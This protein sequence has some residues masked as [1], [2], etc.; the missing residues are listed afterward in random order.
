MRAQRWWP[1]VGLLAVGTLQ[2]QREQL[3]LVM[4]ST[5]SLV[6]R[7]Y[8]TANPDSLACLYGVIDSAGVRLDSAVVRVSCAPP[9][10]GAL[11]VGF[12]PDSMTVTP[13]V[14]QL[15]G[16]L[17]AHPPFRLV[18]LI[19]GIVRR[20]DG[21]RVPVLVACWAVRGTSP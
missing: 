14:A 1:L 2:A 13:M 12:P 3:P 5:T 19:V 11:G 10:F 8:Y 20:P 6:L 21:L 7:R 17:R 18:G 15:C 4:D 16:V 9:A